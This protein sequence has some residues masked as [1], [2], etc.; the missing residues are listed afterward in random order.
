MEIKLVKH[1]NFPIYGIGK[2]D[3]HQISVNGKVI[4]EFKSGKCFCNPD[5]LMYLTP[6]SLNGRKIKR[7]ECE[8]QRPVRCKFYGN[9]SK[10]FDHQELP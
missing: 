9:R 3:I 5:N 10:S 2:V 7:D 6:T 8:N 4:V 1:K